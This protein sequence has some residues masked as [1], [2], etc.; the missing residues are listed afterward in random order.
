MRSVALLPAFALTAGAWVGAI[1]PEWSPAP[2]WLVVVVVGAWMTWCTR[3]DGPVV[4]ALA[5]GYAL[6]GVLLAAS[7]SV[8]AARTP[9]RA[10]LDARF[11]GFAM[12]RLDPAGTHP[13]LRTR[14]RLTEDAARSD[15]GVRLR[16]VVEQLWIDGVPRPAH[17]GVVVTVSGAMAA[18]RLGAWRAGRRLDVPVTFRRPVRYLNAG[19]ADAEAAAARQGVTLLGRTKSGL[20]VEVAARGGWWTEQAAGVR[21]V[22]RRRVAAYVGDPAGPRPGVRA[23]IVTA[24]LI[25]DRTAIPGEVR[26]RLQAAGTYHVIAISGGNIAVLVVLAMT[27]LRAAGAGPRLAAG[28]AVPLLLAYAGVVTGGPSVRRAVVMAVVYLTARAVDVRAPV[29]NT[30]AL[31]AAGLL[32]ADPLDVLDA[33]FWLTFGATAALVGAGR[34]SARTDTEGDSGGRIAWPRRVLGV[35][36]AGTLAST[37]VELV[38]VPVTLVAFSRVTLA[39][40]AANLVAV[41]AMT[42]AQ[43]AGLVVAAGPPAPVAQLCG[44]TAGLATDVLLASSAV[45]DWAPWLSPRVPAPPAWV[46]PCYGGLLAAA[47]R[48]PRPGPALAALCVAV[49]LW[50]NWPPAGA[51]DH[52]RLTLTALDVGQGDAILLGL[53][54]GRAV[55]VDAGGGPAGG[56]EVGERVVG[57][58]LWARGIRR[59]HG[60]VVTHADPDHVGGAAAIL[61]DFRP[62]VLWTGIRV[63]GHEPTVLLERHARAAGVREEMLVRGGR[64]ELGGA[65]VRVLHPPPADWERPR[66]RNDDSIVLEVRFGDVAILL[67]G[68]AGIDVER[69]LLDRLSPASV[70]VLKVGHHGSRT[71]TGAALVGRW[72]PQVAVISSGRGNPFGHPAPDVLH[73]LREVGAHVFRTDREGEVTIETD[74]RDVT[75]R[76]FRSAAPVRLA[77]KSR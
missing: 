24:L 72:A 11:G 22:V 35:L 1:R 18:G 15:G 34:L 3:A 27:L 6:T 62:T 49:G 13:P 5:A 70:R 45:V 2:S 30:L 46:W 19:V 21:A 75:V 26:G 69:E 50:A 32:I 60:L 53:P 10:V 33:G 37:L 67:T 14:L 23:G 68:D 8:G 28:L 54:D 71:S 41:P 42:V 12:D 40:I 25:G 7:A 44:F 39:G 9:L 31:G 65:T 51:A 36:L 55:L 43:L 64:F 73:R 52:G 61:D 63:P 4:A 29:W 76:T 77:T 48:A 58:A 47:W 59:L 57:P 17:G 20:A 74:G 38:I 56:G 66:V 16:G